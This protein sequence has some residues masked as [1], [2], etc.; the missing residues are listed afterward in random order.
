M[1]NE[2][3]MKRAVLYLRVSTKDQTVENQ[4]LELKRLAEARGWRIVATF[5]DESERLIWLHYH[6]DV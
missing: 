5:R 4:R 1:N 2:S 3:V 6:H